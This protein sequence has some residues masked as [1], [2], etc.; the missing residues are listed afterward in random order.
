MSMFHLHR[1]FLI[2][3]VAAFASSNALASEARGLVTIGMQRV[4]EHMKPNFETASGQKLD[5]EFASTPDIAK[6]VMDGSS[7]TSS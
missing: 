4:F 5:V 2:I 3:L 1:L 7:W 6:R